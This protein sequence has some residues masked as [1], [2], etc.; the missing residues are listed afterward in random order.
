MKQGP[1]D[2][3]QVLLLVVTVAA[4]ASLTSGLEDAQHLSHALP[5]CLALCP[6]GTP[7]MCELPVV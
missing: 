5:E 1:A 3:V 6:S 7:Q 4:A 2:F